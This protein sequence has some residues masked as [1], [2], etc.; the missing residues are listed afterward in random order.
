MKYR[1][2]LSFVLLFALGYMFVH[3][4][5]FSVSHDD[6][7]SVQEYISEVTTSTSDDI[8]DIHDVHF[9]YHLEYIFHT[10]SLSFY[11][12]TKQKLS[13]YNKM[14]LSWEYFNFLRPPIV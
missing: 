4:Y 5:A 6:R 9:E 11:N 12:D 7:H 3:D 13:S 14:C 10:A 8:K 1:S 2:V